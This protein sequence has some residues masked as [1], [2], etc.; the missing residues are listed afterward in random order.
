V[1]L[2][3]DHCQL[4][5]TIK[6][7]EA[8]KKG[9]GITL[10]ERIINSPILEPCARLLDVQYR[11]NEKI[12]EW[13]SHEMYQ[14][15]LRSH[16]SNSHHT[17]GGLLTHQRNEDLDELS[18][19]VMLLIDTAGC[20]IEESNC[21]GGSYR[22]PTEAEIVVA[23]IYRLYELGLKPEQIGVITPY[24][25]QLEVLRELVAARE[26]AKEGVISDTT[27]SAKG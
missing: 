26:E 9:L 14:D 2:A 12:S 1:V 4:P 27:L 25:G 15:R 3:G 19:T 5:P 17:L 22:N 21:R 16:E 18:A 24:N 10:F 13:S 6:S 8:E 7:I 23:H 11:M 20:N